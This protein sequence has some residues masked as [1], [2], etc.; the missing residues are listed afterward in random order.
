MRWSESL[1]RHVRRQLGDRAHVIG[2]VIVGAALTTVSAAAQAPW[3]RA[4]NNLATTFTG[5]LA[6]SLALVAIVIGGLMFMFGE[7]GAKRQISGIVFGGGLA[8]LRGQFP[9]VVILIRRTASSQGDRSMS[10]HP[11]YRTRL[12][13]A[14]PAA[15]IGGVDRRLFFLSLL[16]GAAAFNL[17]YSFLAGLLMFVGLYGCALWATRRDPRC[18]ASCW[19]HPRPGAGMTLGNTIASTWRSCRAED[20]TNPP[21]L[22]RGGQCQQPVGAVGVRRRD[23][24]LD[25]GRTRRGGVSRPGCRLR[26]LTHGQRRRSGPS[27]RGALR[28]LD[29]RCRVYQYLLK[30]TIDSDRRHNRVRNRSRTRRFRSERPTSTAAA[31]T[32][33]SSRCISW[34]CTKRR[35][36]PVPAPRLRNVWRAPKDAVRGWLSTREALTLVESEGVGFGSRSRPSVAHLHLDGFRLMMERRQSLD[37]APIRR[38]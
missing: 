7:A 11:T 20:R 28:L 30:R 26:R 33:T 10:D 6:R 5:P 1:I 22:L 31:Q 21:R 17:F 27:V 14:S 34:C 32:S 18:S 9:C 35:P 23:D 24:V 8:L 16:L 13:G 38:E 4:A 3:E 37:R 36:A 25:E 15:T 2:A 29:D 12:Q 19:H